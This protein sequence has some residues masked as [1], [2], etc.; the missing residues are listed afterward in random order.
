MLAAQSRS[1]NPI[2]GGD[3]HFRK[4]RQRPQSFFDRTKPQ[5]VPYTEMEHLSSFEISQ[6]V[7]LFLF[8]L[9]HY[10][11]PQQ[12]AFDGS[13][14]SFDAKDLGIADPIK[15]LR[16]PDQYFRHIG[17]AAKCSQQDFHGG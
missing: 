4:D 17:T 12:L 15:M 10:Q 6:I 14:V 16:I 8:V 2:S 7:E 5:Q 9:E 1:C 13:F 11:C 3:E